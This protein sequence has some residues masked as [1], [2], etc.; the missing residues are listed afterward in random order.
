[1]NQLGL[2]SEEIKPAAPV[3]IPKSR[4]GIIP[5]DYQVEDHDSTFR[6]WDARTVGTLTRGFTGCGNCLGCA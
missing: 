4:A 6:L 5:R 2:F 3:A 1:M